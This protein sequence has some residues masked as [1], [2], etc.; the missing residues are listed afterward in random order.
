[1]LGGEASALRAGV[2]SEALARQLEMSGGN[3]VGLQGGA[4]ELYAN[5]RAGK[6]ISTQTAASIEQARRYNALQD[7]LKGKNMGGTGKD[8]TRALSL[9]QAGKAAEQEALLRRARA[10]AMRKFKIQG[11]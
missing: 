7:L 10:E 9:D 2:G 5:L 11:E 8:N 4:N 6:D 3:I 1:M